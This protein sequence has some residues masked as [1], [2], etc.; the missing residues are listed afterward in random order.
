MTRI[1]KQHNSF[2][3]DHIA[4]AATQPA[5][6]KLLEKRIKIYEV[7][8]KELEYYGYDPISIEAAEDLKVLP[9]LF[10]FVHSSRAP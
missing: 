2:L 6:A 4:V 10:K 9:M 7:L 5:V 3:L 1:G 8:K